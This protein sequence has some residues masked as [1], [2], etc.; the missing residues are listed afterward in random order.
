M[1]EP[2]AVTLRP[3]PRQV[4]ADALADE[5]RSAGVEVERGRARPGRARGAGH[6]G[7]RPP[8]RG[9]RRPGDAAGP[10]SQAV[11][12][13]LGPAPGERVADVAAAPGGKATA[14]AERVGASGAV[15]ALDVDAGRVRMI[16]GVRHRIGLPHLFPLV[17]DGRRP[18][19]REGCFDRVLLDAPC[20]RHRRAAPPP[21]CP[22]AAGTGRRRR[23]RRAAARPARRR[24][25]VGAPGWHARLLGVHA[26][27]RGDV[28]VDDWAARAL[29]ELHGPTP[30]GRTV[31]ARTAGARCCCRRRPAPTACSSS[32]C[33]R[34]D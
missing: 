33:E 29:P 8:A 6:R 20:S 31:D 9:A 15:V 16:D 13:V 11:V 24:G 10:G 1:N 7:S 32:R 18:P 17:G 12:A 5:L 19:L 3:D 30:P 28:G 34:T 25:A 4:T 23:A 22:L 21:R 27:P 2:A 26:H 14:I